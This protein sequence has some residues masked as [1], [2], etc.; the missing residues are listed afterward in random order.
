MELRL[1]NRRSEFAMCD[2]LRGSARTLR[3]LVVLGVTC[4]CAP[5]HADEVPPP[6][7]PFAEADGVQSQLDFKA[8]DKGAAA[9]LT[10]ADAV[11][12]PPDAADV[13]ADVSS[14]DGTA[15]CYENG[16]VSP[17]ACGD[18]L[19]VTQTGDKCGISGTQ[20]CYD[21]NP[22]TFDGPCE[23]PD[24]GTC[25]AC[26]YN[27]KHS[28]KLTLE[29][30]V[31]CPAT[32]RAVPP[33]AFRMGVGTF[34]TCPVV[35]Q[36][37]RWIVFSQWLL[38]DT[39]EVTVGAWCQAAKSTSG[40]CS[41]PRT[42]GNK[43]K[44]SVSWQ[45]ARSHCQARGDGADLCSEAEWEYAARWTSSR[46]YPWGDSE[47]APC[48]KANV[49]ECGNLGPLPTEPGWCSNVAWALSGWCTEW[50]SSW[51]TTLCNMTGNVSEWVLDRFQPYSLG[52][53]CYD[54]DAVIEPGDLTSDRVVRG[55][56]WQT[57]LRAAATYAR[58]GRAPT[59]GY[60]DVGFRCCRRL[61]HEPLP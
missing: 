57:A 30:Q 28:P 27:C 47:S 15:D 24:P 38:I 5:P 4:A 41:L 1:R 44:V 20:T 18:L 7:P 58:D 56:S 25:V 14:V 54:R 26:E 53:W 37:P 16:D 36:P 17:P 3:S 12:D 40:I 59:L 48:L 52:G 34:A 60:P 33:G 55:G 51:C 49:A 61:Q 43:P 23:A 21:G 8:W 22:C 39:E 46:S 19:D 42:N 50:T 6:E 31:L 2:T 35:Q 9:D 10:E 29:G 45:E 11:A 13:K 32:M